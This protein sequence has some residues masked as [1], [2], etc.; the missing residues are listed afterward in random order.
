MQ[1]NDEEQTPP[2]EMITIEESYS[3]L[4][5][6]TSDEND[7]MN[8]YFLNYNLLKLLFTKHHCEFSYLYKD[9]VFFDCLSL[10]YLGISVL[11]L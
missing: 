6:Y 3:N 10:S 4:G 2:Y 9:C 1:A 8:N 11:M 7:K 5:G